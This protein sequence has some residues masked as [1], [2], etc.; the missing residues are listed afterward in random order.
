M[1][2]GVINGG[3]RQAQSLITCHK[4]QDVTIRRAHQRTGTIR[5][6]KKPNQGEFVQGQGIFDLCACRDL[7]WSFG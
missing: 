3:D 2:G 1:Q 5:R 4:A 6:A 7:R